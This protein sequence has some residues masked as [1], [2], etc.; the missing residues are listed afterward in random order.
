MTSTR[1]WSALFTLVCGV[2]GC[3]LAVT[4]LFLAGCGG[5]TGLDGG[6]GQSVS[7][8]TSVGEAGNTTR[9]LSALA[10]WSVSDAT[11]ASISN[12]AAARGQV[13]PIKAG[14]A[15]VTATYQGVSGTDDVTVSATTLASINVTPGSATI[16]QH[17][18]QAFVATGTLSDSTTLDLTN[19]VTWLSTVPGQASIS[20]ANGSRGVVTGIATGSVTIS[21]VRGT[22]SG[23][24][25]LTVQ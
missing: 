21:A 18:T 1:I 24:A 20:N 4:C 16:A 22:L 14:K 6:K 7:G 8:N 19:Y 23:T 3:L 2:L 25:T 15:T 11:V 17:G 10:T 9:D 13:A 5:A 12:A